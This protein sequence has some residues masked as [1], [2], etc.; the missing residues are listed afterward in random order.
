MGKEGKHKDLIKGVT[1]FDIEANGFLDEATKI[2]CIATR[3]LDSREENFFGPDQIEEGVAYLE[4][5]EIVAAHNGIG[6]DYPLLMKLYPDFKLPK[7]EDTL[8]LSR[9]FNPDRA[10]HSIEQWGITFG[11][12][13]PEHTDWTTYSDAMGHRCAEDTRILAR[14]IRHLLSEMGDHDWSA[15]IACEYYTQWLQNKIE[16]YGVRLSREVY[17]AADH[18]AALTAEKGAILTESLPLLIKRKGTPVLKPFTNKGTLAKRV[19]NILGR[20]VDV[21]G[22]FSGV[23]FVPLNLNSPKQLTDF[24]Y[25]IGW[26]PTEFN[27]KKA[28]RGGY[29]LNPDGTYVISSPKVT[30]DSLEPLDHPVAKHLKEFRVLKHRLSILRHVKKDG[31]PTGWC[32]T[33][34]PDDHRLE[35][36]A[37][38][39]G[40]NTGRYVHSNIVNLPG[41]DTPH[42]DAVR[43]MLVPSDGLVMAGTD[44]VNIQA[45]CG[46]IAAYP[47]DDGEYAQRLLAGDFHTRNA[48]ALS[49]ASGLEITRQKA[50]GI[51]FALMFGAQTRKIATMLGCSL[52]LAEVL[53]D[54]FWKETPGLG[55]LHQKCT[56]DARGKGWLAGL[57]GRKIYVRSPHS[58]MNALFQNMEAVSFKNVILRM[59]D[60]RWPIVYTC[61][62]EFLCELK[63]RYCDAYLDRCTAV[64]A[65]VSEMYG[66]DKIIPIELDTAFGE[67]YAACH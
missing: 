64:A 32:N 22:P 8:I 11:Q 61:H 10:G 2:H 31:T 44:M 23:E 66:W 41:V 21:R 26:E 12:P 65:E 6:Y 5:C 27:Y 50:K 35:A 45:R 24:L 34:R 51:G 1:A 30:E 7:Y 25:S 54:T 58:A 39:C 13:K 3:N 16:S 9:L 42:A 43:S 53:I 17:K 59:D 47:Y 40:T 37:I 20:P 67:D 55:A 62:D 36:R 46:G 14:V 19:T 18:L 28:K 4:S 33:V 57:D 49:Q 15:A 63:E 52:D 60:D 29:E 48:T 56:D 38:P